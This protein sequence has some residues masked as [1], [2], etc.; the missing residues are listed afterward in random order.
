MTAQRF[1]E[2]VVTAVLAH[3]NSDHSDDNLLITRAFVSADIDAATMT[4]LDGSG[5]DWRVSVDGKERDVRIPWSVAVTERAEIRRE[6]VVL[7]ETACA[8]L[9]ITPRNH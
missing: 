3:M 1:D 7:Y 4:W 5:G 8:R 2:N 9:G 6:V